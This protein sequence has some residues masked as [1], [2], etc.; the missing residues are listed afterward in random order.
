MNR[1]LQSVLSRGI[2]YS[3]RCP[4]SAQFRAAIRRACKC[5]ANINHHNSKW[6]INSLFRLFTLNTRQHAHYSGQKLAQLLPLWLLGFRL[7]QSQN[8]YDS[9]RLTDLPN[10]ADSIY[11]NWPTI[12]NIS[13]KCQN[14]LQT[15]NI[16]FFYLHLITHDLFHFHGLFIICFYFFGWCK[17]MIIADCAKYV[18]SQPKK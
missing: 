12:K 16:I 18:Q 13:Q 5:T 3:I 4:I 15:A 6:F 9:L 8:H 2:L 17:K 10:N 14:V 7:E 1:S 11:K